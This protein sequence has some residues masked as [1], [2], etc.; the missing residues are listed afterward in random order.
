M[1]TRAVE[2][3]SKKTQILYHLRRPLLL[4]LDRRLYRR[5]KELLLEGLR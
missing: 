1:E 5:R 3:M 2:S 4:A